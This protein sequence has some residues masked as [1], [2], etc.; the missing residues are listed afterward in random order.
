MLDA[1]AVE[2]GA[3]TAETEK[4]V[5]PTKLRARGML[6]KSN[7]MAVLGKGKNDPSTQDATQADV[8]DR[9]ERLVVKGDKALESF[10]SKRRTSVQPPAPMVQ[11]LQTRAKEAAK[12]HAHATQAQQKMQ[13]EGRLASGGFGEK[14]SQQR[15][16]RL[17]GRQSKL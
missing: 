16:T 9:M 15:H 3:G 2:T 4:S 17:V 1:A 14:K 10:K 11:A 8:E 5:T 12:A 13:A 7:M 6:Q